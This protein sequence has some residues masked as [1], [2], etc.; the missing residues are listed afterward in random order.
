MEITEQQS[1]E[2]K[3]KKPTF[4]F[5]TQKCMFLSIEEEPLLSA[6]LV[7]WF[8]VCPA[9]L[10]YVTQSHFDS[11]EEGRR[12]KIYALSLQGILKLIRSSGSDIICVRLLL[13]IR[14][15]I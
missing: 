13:M 3:K 9:E 5:S 12:S 6:W 7:S 4:N 10:M 15:A 1:E 8:C 14:K 2:K 11:T